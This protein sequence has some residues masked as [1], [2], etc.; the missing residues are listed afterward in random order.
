MLAHTPRID[1]NETL[2]TN[3]TK[4]KIRIVKSMVRWADKFTEGRYYRFSINTGIEEDS[5]AECE[6]QSMVEAPTV[7]YLDHVDQN[8]QVRRCVQR[9]LQKKNMCINKLGAK[10]RIGTRVTMGKQLVFGICWRL[11]TCWKAH[12]CYCYSN[13]FKVGSDCTPLLSNQPRLYQWMQVWVFLEGLKVSDIRVWLG[14]QD[15]MVEFPLR[16][17][18]NLC[19]GDI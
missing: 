7:N 12:A 14:T 4:S 2:F 18:V 15:K 6:K 9:F 16:S 19:W 11:L 17:S 10:R 13:S 3:A 1:Y 5:L 8:Y